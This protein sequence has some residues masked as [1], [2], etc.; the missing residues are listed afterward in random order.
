MPKNFGRAGAGDFFEEMCE[1][2]GERWGALQKMKR[3]EQAR[4]NAA[5][6]WVLCIGKKKS[7]GCRN[8]LAAWLLHTAV[9]WVA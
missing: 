5:K 8:L 3:G 4:K 2:A 9:L 6:K 7:C 1:G